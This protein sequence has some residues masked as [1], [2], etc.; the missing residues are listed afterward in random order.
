VDPVLRDDQRDDS[1][2]LGDHEPRIL[3]GEGNR[4]KGR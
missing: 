1:S 4:R 2:E 3:P